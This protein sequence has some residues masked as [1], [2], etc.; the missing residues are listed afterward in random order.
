MDVLKLPKRRFLS[1]SPT[2]QERYV[3]EHLTCPMCES[4]LHI[5]HQVDKRELKITEEAFCPLCGIRARSV[6]YSLH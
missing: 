1:S 2:H 6:S 4:E 5:Q 3:F